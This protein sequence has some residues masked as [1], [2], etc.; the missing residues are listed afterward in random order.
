[1]LSS[2]IWSRSAEAAADAA[3]L[4]RISSPLIILRRMAV[5]AALALVVLAP[6]STAAPDAGPTP[7]PALFIGPGGTDAGR[8]NR[9][10]PCA[11]FDRA[12]AL[13]RPGAVVEVAAGTYGE[14]T[15]R[16]RAGRRAPNVVFRPA[17]GS[18]VTVAG[19]LTV[20]AAY[21]EIRNM[22]VNDLEVQREADHVTFRGVRNRGFWVQGASNV[23]FA[24][25][26]VTCG[27]CPFHPFLV[28]GGPPDHRPP[29]KIVFDGVY[30]HDW[31]A[32]EAGQHTECL[33]ILAGD[34][35]TIRNSVFRNCATADNGRG[36]T[37]SLHV[38]WLGNGPKTSNVLIE[39]NFFYRSG[40]TYAIQAGDYRN[41]DFRYNSV[42][43]AIVVF[44]GYGD[45]TPVE[46]VGN[47][48]RFS[49][50]EAPRL[51]TGTIAPLVYRY[52]VLDGGR[53]HSTDLSAPSGFKDASRDLRLRRGAAA[54]DRGSP[55]TYP[56][57]DIDGDRRPKGGRPDAGADEAG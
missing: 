35:V 23:T 46:L 44:G 10:T 43:A 30:F 24:G 3:T 17:A 36:A 57:R 9:S 40:N 22:A 14:Q 19:E 5:L 13:A 26:E 1:M 7:L 39:N 25:G 20:R 45:G 15:V 27:R 55:G 42:A 16:F 29:R 41:L 53:C 28:D 56:R 2:R 54:I 50:C 34:G 38:S 31:H 37:A 8:C 52:N 33:Q 49:G 32:A 12:Y 4:A 47:V 48:M 6:P 51:G 18:R 11:S 21:L